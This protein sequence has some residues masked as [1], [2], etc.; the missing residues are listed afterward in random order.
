MIIALAVVA[1]VGFCFS[2]LLVVKR[3][4]TPK[5]RSDRLRRNF[6]E[7]QRIEKLR[8]FMEQI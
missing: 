5:F 1:F 6:A 2:V 8:Q 7:I 4:P 3:K